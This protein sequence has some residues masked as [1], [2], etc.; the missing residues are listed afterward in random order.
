MRRNFNTQKPPFE[1]IQKRENTFMKQHI[2]IN[3]KRQ[4]LHFT[5]KVVLHKLNML[6]K[7]NGYNTK[8]STLFEYL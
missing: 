2:M 6:Q 4:P 7:L 1:S 5:V 3:T 8:V